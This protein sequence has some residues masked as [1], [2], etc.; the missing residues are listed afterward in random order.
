MEERC[1]NCGKYPFCKETQGG[2]YT[3]KNWKKREREL[4]LVNK[5]GENFEFKEIGKRED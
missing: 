5:D 2:N 1:T 3:C 4:M